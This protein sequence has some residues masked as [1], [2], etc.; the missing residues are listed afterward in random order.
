MHTVTLPDVWLGR[1]SLV[2]TLARLLLGGVVLVAG[3]L[4]VASPTQSV[5]AVQA[6]RLLPVPVSQVVGHGLPFLEIAVGLLLIAGLGVRVSALVAGVLMLVF[7]AA[8][9]SAWAR[10]LS[11][12]CGCFGNGGA[13]AAGS[14]R[15][16]QEIL[17]DLGLLACAALLVAWPHTRFAVDDVMQKEDTR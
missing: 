16:V 7:V 1:I 13:V 17:R 3:A 15:Y 8:I 5:Q 4:K 9:A 14:T 6:Y 11:I 10:G 2:G 12:D